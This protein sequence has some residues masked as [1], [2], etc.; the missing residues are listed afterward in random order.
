MKRSSAAVMKGL[1]I[2]MLLALHTLANAAYEG[3]YD[4]TC[5]DGSH[6]DLVAGCSPAFDTFFLIPGTSPNPIVTSLW[7]SDFHLAAI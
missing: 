3:A 2:G 6:L 4:T 7:Q 5:E 1:V